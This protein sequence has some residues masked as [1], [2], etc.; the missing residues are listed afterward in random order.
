MSTNGG[1]ILS[2]TKGTMCPLMLPTHRPTAGGRERV[3][4]N[5]PALSVTGVGKAHARRAIRWLRDRSLLA[6]YRDEDR[7]LN[8]FEFKHGREWTYRVLDD[9]LAAT[10]QAA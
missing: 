4:A 1:D 6:F 7:S 3:M 10:R 5:G 9:A 2:L 8:A